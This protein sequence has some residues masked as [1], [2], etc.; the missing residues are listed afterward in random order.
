MFKLLHQVGDLIVHIVDAPIISVPC[1]QS[2]FGG[3]RLKPFPMRGKPASG[4]LYVC[5]ALHI[6]R[7]WQIWVVEVVKI[8]KHEKGFSVG[9]NPL[10]SSLSNI[11]RTDSSWQVLHQVKLNQ[12]VRNLAAVESV[13]KDA[14]PV[15]EVIL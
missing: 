12:P 15:L 14:S 7:R 6:G 5:V 9:I 2:L 10:K 8:Y 4:I 1:C 13:R 11:G 3:Q